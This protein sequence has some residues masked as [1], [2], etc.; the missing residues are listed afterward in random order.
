[1]SATLASPVHR[2]RISAAI[3]SALMTRSGAS[4]TKPP[5][6]SLWTRRTPRGRRGRARAEPPRGRLAHASSAFGANAPGGVFWCNMGIIQ[7][8]EHRPKHTAFEIERSKNR[9]LLRR[10]EDVAL[11][12]VKCEVC[13]AFGLWRTLLEIGGV[14]RYE[15]VVVTCPPRSLM[16]SGENGSVGDE[17]IASRRV[18]GGGRRRRLRAAWRAAALGGT[19]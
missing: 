1:M 17:A 18:R 13:V 4:S 15:R 6:A 2:L 11:G 16:M 5:C 7:C 9:L 12:V 14:T 3:A 10:G 19:T 8:I